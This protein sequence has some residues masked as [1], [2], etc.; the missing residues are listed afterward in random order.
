MVQ[1]P[2]TRGVGAT[3]DYIRKN[4][5]SISAREQFPKLRSIQYVPRPLRQCSAPLL[6]ENIFIFQKP[7]GPSNRPTIGYM[8]LC[9]LSGDTYKAMRPRQALVYQSAGF[10][11]IFSTK[12]R[13]PPIRTL[14][15][16]SFRRKFPNITRFIY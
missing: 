7:I 4:N 9:I 3:I 14:P 10:V 16:T 13:Q 12:S 1:S 6:Y 2:T 11:R 15:L 5:R 8:I